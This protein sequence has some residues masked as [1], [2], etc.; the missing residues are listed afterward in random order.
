MTRHSRRK[1]YPIFCTKQRPDTEHLRRQALLNLFD[2]AVF[3]RCG[4]AKPAALVSRTQELDEK[5]I[6]VTNAGASATGVKHEKRIFAILDLR[7]VVS[8]VFLLFFSWRNG[9]FQDLKTYMFE[10]IGLFFTC[11]MTNPDSMIYIP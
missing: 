6:E 11:R 4:A 3:V 10:D 5:T 7:R 9:R 1:G 2:L 8:R